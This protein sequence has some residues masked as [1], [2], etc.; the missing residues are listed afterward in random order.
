MEASGILLKKVV[1]DAHGKELY[2]KSSVEMG[3]SSFQV[4]TSILSVS[5]PSAFFQKVEVWVRHI[6][7]SATFLKIFTLRAVSFN[8]LNKS[9]HQ[10]I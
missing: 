6:H 8:F 10:T 7:S 5:Q 1:V 3:K 9:C 4:I 2:Y